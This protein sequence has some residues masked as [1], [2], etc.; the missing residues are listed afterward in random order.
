[1]IKST[2][3]NQIIPE[4]CLQFT[5]STPAVNNPRLE[6]LWCLDAVGIHDPIMVNDYDEALERFTKSIKFDRGRYQVTWPCK[7]EDSCLSDNYFL[8]L[9]RMKMLMN[10]LQ[11]DKELLHKYDH[12]IQ[13]QVNAGIIEEVVDVCGSSTRKYYLPHHPVLTPDKETTKIR[14]VY[15]ASAKAQSASRNLNECLYCGPVI[16]PD[17]CGIL[18]RFQMY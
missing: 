13:Q 12:V 10:R 1:M 18:I 4:L 8:A 2:E 6:D 7:C 3:I 9:S 16:L 14:I 17:L 5:I 15:D 11:S